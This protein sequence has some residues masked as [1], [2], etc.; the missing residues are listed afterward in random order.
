MTQLYKCVFTQEMGTYVLLD[1]LVSEVGMHVRKTPPQFY[2]YLNTYLFKKG[3]CLF[4]RR[5]L[6][7]NRDPLG[8][9]PKRCQFSLKVG[10]RLHQGVEILTHKVK[11]VY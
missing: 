9:G 7:F 6:Y 1:T 3:R 4:R 11:V 10:L 8:T 5:H 2:I